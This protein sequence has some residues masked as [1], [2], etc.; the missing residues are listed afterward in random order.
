MQRIQGILGVLKALHLG[1]LTHHGGEQSAHQ[2][3]HSMLQFASPAIIGGVAA[4]GQG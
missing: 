4:E 3:N 1:S 2:T